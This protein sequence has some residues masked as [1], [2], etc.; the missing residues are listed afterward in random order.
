VTRRLVLPSRFTPS[1]FPINNVFVF[2]PLHCTWPSQLEA[3]DFVILIT[4]GEEYRSRSFP[5]VCNFI[6]RVLRTISKLFN[7]YNI[8]ACK[9][10]NTIDF[11]KKNKEFQDIF[12]IHFLPHQCYKDARDWIPASGNRDKTDH[13]TGD[14]TC[15]TYKLE[16]W[17]I[18][19][20]ESH[21]IPTLGLGL[22]LNCVRA[23]WH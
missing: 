16:T 10:S 21:L 2:A 6:S 20:W 9:R 12:S 5:C 13:H 22:L 18:V 14:S 19:A 17:Q 8:S 23:S 3:C 4:L 11:V 1:V 7:I 15:I